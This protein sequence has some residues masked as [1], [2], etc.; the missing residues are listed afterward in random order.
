MK[1][2]YRPGARRWIRRALCRSIRGPRWCGTAICTS[3]ACGTTRSGRGEHARA[4]RRHDPRA[5]CAGERAVRR[6]NVQLRTVRPA[7]R[8]D[9]HAAARLPAGPGAAALRRGGS[10]R[11]VLV[12]GRRRAATRAAICRSAGHH[13]AA[14]D[15]ENRSVGVTDDAAG[16]VRPGK[17][18]CSGAASGTPPQAASGRRCGW[19][20]VL[21]EKHPR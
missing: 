1:R 21:R 18:R 20:A 5:L 14:E 3:M 15:G 19:R 10:V 11:R 16:R 12:N 8:A 4:G 2:L 13:G 17:Q 9:V 6:G 7:V